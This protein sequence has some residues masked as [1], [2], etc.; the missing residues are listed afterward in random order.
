MEI[1]DLSPDKIHL[2]LVLFLVVLGLLFW[3]T[4]T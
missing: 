4:K 3:W 1:Q 2:G